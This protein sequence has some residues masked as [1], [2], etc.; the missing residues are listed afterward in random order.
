MDI[1]FSSSRFGPGYE[2]AEVD[3]F[4]DR[5]ERALA[6]GDASVTEETVRGARFSQ[7]RFREGYDVA[8]VDSYLED[9]MAPRLRDAAGGVP[10]RSEP[11]RPVAE[12][13]PTER[14]GPVPRPDE[15]RGGFLSR[16]L[17]GR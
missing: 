12:E 15:H 11:S 8:E 17:R 2:M 4:L 10:T 3:E 14:S 1:R 9:V 13:P 6:T 7:T 16:L 5:C